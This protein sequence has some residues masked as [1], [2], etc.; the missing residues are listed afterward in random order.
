MKKST[1]LK[2][3]KGIKEDLE[4][5]LENASELMSKCVKH[6]H[7]F[8]DLEMVVND[9]KYSVDHLLELERE[10]EGKEDEEKKEAFMLY[11]MPCEE[12]VTEKKE[13]YDFDW[14]DEDEEENKKDKEDKEDD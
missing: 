7:M 14:D 2:E 9:T 4:K 12:C 1:A 8:N 13:E 6:K 3:I 5:I 10:I 11:N